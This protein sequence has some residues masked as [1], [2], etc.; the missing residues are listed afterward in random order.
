MKRL[1]NGVEVELEDS[2]A[3]IS[4]LSDRVLVRTPEGSFSALAVRQGDTVHVS[5]KG[6][7]YRIEKAG[8]R[9]SGAG[10]ASSGEMKAPMPGLI[11][12]VI[13]A[14]GAE[15]EKGDKLLILEAMKTQ[16]TF[17]APFKGVVSKLA[18]TK[19]QQ[20]TEGQLMVLVESSDE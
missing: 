20:V 3:D 7:T 9:R 10:G 16:Q 5:Y 6:R 4:R 11:V 8:G 15:V 18:V 2:A 12:D 14:E 1:V 19:G 13:T 17:T